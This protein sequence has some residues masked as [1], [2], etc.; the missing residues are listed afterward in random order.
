MLRVS[1]IQTSY[2]WPT[3]QC[4]N[5]GRSDLCHNQDSTHRIGQWHTRHDT[6]IDD[7][8]VV[9]RTIISKSHSI[10]W[11]CKL[12]GVP[13]FGV[14]INYRVRGA[15]TNLG[16]ASP[17]IGSVY[18]VSDMCCDRG[19]VVRRDQSEVRDLLVCR[20]HVCDGS[21]EHSLVDG[22]REPWAGDYSPLPRLIDA[23]TAVS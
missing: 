15:G 18:H 16:R 3:S 4:Q 20:E 10:D 8:Q 12:T 19:N 17:V 23:F 6:S 9:C 13:N 14:G 5:L 1:T 22:I 7:E 21:G 2:L 11:G